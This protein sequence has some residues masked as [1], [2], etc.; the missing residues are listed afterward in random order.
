MK[1]NLKK[2][3]KSNYTKQ[4]Y[5]ALNV[6]YQVGNRR[7]LIDYDYLDKLSPEE[8]EWLD[9]FTSEYV[10]TNFAHKNDPLIT[11]KEERKELYKQNN[12]RNNDIFAIS[13]SN[14]KLNYGLKT[15]GDSSNEGNQRKN[16]YAEKREQKPDD[17]EDY[18]LTLITLKR[19]KIDDLL[20]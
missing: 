13:K 7:E 10:I 6:K 15:E 14:N 8:K 3:K 1:K 9:R 16:I 11:D 12:R 5:P 4:K 20:D 17:I 18:L 2:K 19:I